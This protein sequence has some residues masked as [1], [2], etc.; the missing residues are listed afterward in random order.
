MNSE[1]TLESKYFR[2]YAPHMA[3]QERIRNKHREMAEKSIAV[4]AGL[5]T[6]VLLGYGVVHLASIAKKSTKPIEIKKMMIKEVP[7]FSMQA[8]LREI[9]FGLAGRKI[10]ILTSRRNQ[11]FH[12][13]VHTDAKELW[14]EFFMRYG[15][16]YKILNL[17]ELGNLSNANLVIAP[18]FKS[19]SMKQR[20]VLN[21][22]K[23]HIVYTGQTGH[24]NGLGNVSN[25]F[26]LRGTFGVERSV[27][28][29]I[30]EFSD[31]QMSGA[32]AL[33][34]FSFF[35]NILEQARYQINGVD[36]VFLT[37]DNRAWLLFDPQVFSASK[38][39]ITGD[40]F[41][42]ELLNHLSK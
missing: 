32:M 18:Q 39:D 35:T 24:L 4:V 17:N 28:V 27:G 37:R 3:D 31:N 14:S 40:W 5:F 8:R 15:I 42:L 7:K 41:F 1:Y 23:G 33:P 9:S 38:T 30:R 26:F 22:F 34:T 2:R 11:K 6:C 29:S 19:L 16:D 21:Q 10:V 20:K 36:K 12:K 13:E 25:D